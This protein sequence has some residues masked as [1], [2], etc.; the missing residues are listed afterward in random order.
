MAKSSEHAAGPFLAPAF[1]V[2]QFVCENFLAKRPYVCLW[3][4]KTYVVPAGMYACQ[5]WGNEHFKAGKDF[6]SDLQVRH[7]NYLQA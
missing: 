3:L 1:W 4:G 5:V 2:R 6:A 7:M